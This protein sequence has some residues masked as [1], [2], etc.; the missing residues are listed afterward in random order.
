MS[1]GSA[2]A[3]KGSQCQGRE[4][5]QMSVDMHTELLLRPRPRQEEQMPM[6]RNVRMVMWIH[7]R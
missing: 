1:R 5:G 7:R 6:G 3:S 4:R 2:K